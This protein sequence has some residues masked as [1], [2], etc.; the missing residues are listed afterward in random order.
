MG[1][2]ILNSLMILIFLSGMVAM[3]LLRTLYR[4]I[5]KYN[6]LA[7]AEEA[8]EEKVVPAAAVTAQPCHHR[9]PLT[10]LLSRMH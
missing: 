9:P 5:T 1:K 3:I 6:E 2:V 7:T 8:A 4:D 10:H